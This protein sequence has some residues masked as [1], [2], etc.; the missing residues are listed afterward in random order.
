MLTLTLQC[1]GECPTIAFIL[2]RAIKQPV[3]VCIDDGYGHATLREVNGAVMETVQ[4]FRQPIIKLQ[5]YANDV[6]R[7]IVMGTWYPERQCW[8]ATVTVPCVDLDTATRDNV[9]QALRR[10]TYPKEEKA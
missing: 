10:F 5:K 2:S 7:A 6:C 1:E 4:D 3:F 9:S 8:L